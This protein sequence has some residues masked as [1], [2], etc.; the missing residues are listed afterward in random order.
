MRQGRCSCQFSPPPAGT[1]SCLVPSLVECTV[2]GFLSQNQLCCQHDRGFKNYDDKKWQVYHI[3]QPFKKFPYSGLVCLQ[4]WGGSAEE[5]G[6][7]SCVFKWRRW[8]GG[9]ED[10]V[11]SRNITQNSLKL[12]SLQQR[13]DTV[14]ISGSYHPNQQLAHK[15]N[16]KRLGWG[17]RL[18][19]LTDLWFHHKKRITCFL[20]RVLKGFRQYLYRNI[21]LFLTMLLSEGQAHKATST[22][23]GP[24]LTCYF[25]TKDHSLEERPLCAYY[26]LM[27]RAT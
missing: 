26:I 25:C 20:F 1:Q 23:Q 4:E 8:G 24:R 16:R 17:D 6:E 2:T 18:L 9:S 5:L 14:L 19:H 21:Y 13:K 27:Q 10:C 12:D 7:S 3:K 22:H 11:Q 15:M